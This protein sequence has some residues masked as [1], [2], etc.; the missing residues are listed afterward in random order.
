M[1]RTHH[2]HEFEPAALAE[3]KGAQ[4][5]SVCL[6]ARDEESTVGAIVATIVHDLVDEVALV[7]E[8]LVVDDHSGDRTAEV[9]ADAGARVVQAGDVLA[10]HG[11][12]HGKGEA[13]WK[14]L[15]ACE[16]DLVV[17]CD[18]DVSDFQSHFV[19]GLLG[20]LLSTD[21]SFVKG[22]YDR[23]ADGPVGGGRVT[24]L[25]ARPTISLL[26]PDLAAVVQPLS[27]EYA[28]RRSVLEQVPFVQGYGVELGLLIDL[29][30]ANGL[31]SMAQVDLG[32][33]NH[34]HRPLDELSPQALAVL[35]T[36]LSRADVLAVEQTLRLVR[37]G[38]PPEALQ[39]GERPALVDLASYRARRPA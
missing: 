8:V 15:Y 31:E 6:P 34:R 13:L 22:F 36:A 18:A 12:G 24:E 26:F 35:H 7:D 33:R 23:S 30:E 1:L 25:V 28:G 37:P 11:T 39:V 21:V 27:G 2:H 9:A 29:V 20:P 19:T 14:S 10:E 17:W 16:G 32:V 4:R 38:Q 3:R 5:I